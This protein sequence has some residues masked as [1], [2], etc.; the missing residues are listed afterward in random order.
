MHKSTKIGQLVHLDVWGPYRVT[1]KDGYKYFLT[2]V[3]YFGKAVWVYLPR[4]KAEVSGY[5]ERFIKLIF[6]Q[7]GEKIKVLRYDKWYK[8]C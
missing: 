3:D 6:T 5:L 4:S 1:N 2:L 8:I 7:F